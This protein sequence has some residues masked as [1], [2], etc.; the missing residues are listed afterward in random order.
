M[1]RQLLG[2]HANLQYSDKARN[3]LNWSVMLLVSISAKYVNTICIM[4]DDAD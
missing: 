2:M 4:I 1:N 3:V